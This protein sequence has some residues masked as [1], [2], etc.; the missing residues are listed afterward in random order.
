MEERDG[1]LPPLSLVEST[2]TNIPVF[3]IVLPDWDGSTGLIEGCGL[4]GWRFMVTLLLLQSRI[5]T[6]P[7]VIN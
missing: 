5:I 3:M 7:V 1:S 4:L 6:A 2:E